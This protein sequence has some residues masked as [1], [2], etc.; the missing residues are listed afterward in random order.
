MGESSKRAVLC[1][2]VST[3]HQQECGYRL[4]TRFNEMREYAAENGIQVIQEFEGHSRRLCHSRTPG[5]DPGELLTRDRPA[6]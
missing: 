3:N 1:A 5:R 4:V 2:R 6:G